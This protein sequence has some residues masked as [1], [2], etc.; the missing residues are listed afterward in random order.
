MSTHIHWKDIFVFTTRMNI[1][2]RRMVIWEEGD[3]KE[4]CGLDELELW[5]KSVFPQKQRKIY[6]KQ[7]W[8]SVS[9]FKNSALC[10]FLYF[11]NV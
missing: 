3:R 11:W 7:I 9:T 5:L 2:S 8:Q 10:Y 1:Y 4:Q 6:L